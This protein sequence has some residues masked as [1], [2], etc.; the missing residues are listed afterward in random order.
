[1]PATSEL[2]IFWTNRAYLGNIG[3]DV[4]GTYYWPSTDNH[5]NFAWEQRFTD[6]NLNLY[7]KFSTEKICKPR[8]KISKL[9]VFYQNKILRILSINNLE[10]LMPYFI[11]NG[12]QSVQEFELTR[13]SCVIEF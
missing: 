1:L 11:K 10:Y 9:A 6:A 2:N 13:V 4:V 8:F 5:V 3:L 7:Y 12:H